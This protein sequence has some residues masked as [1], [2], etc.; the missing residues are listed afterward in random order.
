MSLRSRPSR[1]RPRPRGAALL[2]LAAA[3]TAVL[4]TGGADTRADEC[5]H[6][7]RAPQAVVVAPTESPQVDFCRGGSNVSV[8]GM[9]TQ[10]SASIACPR[11]VTT[12]L[13]YNPIV[14]SLGV[15]VTNRVE[16]YNYRD[17]YRCRRLSVGFGLYQSTRCVAVNRTEV[18]TQ[19][20]ALAEA[21]C[22][23]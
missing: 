23:G 9:S 12:G 3:A 11:W 19:W 22:A 18:E 7:G 8:P 13:S 15:R 1:L 14:A 21:A 4:V 2:V 20:H 6:Q 16:V 17:D 10:Q 5:P